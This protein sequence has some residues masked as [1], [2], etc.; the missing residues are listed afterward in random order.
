MKKSLLVALILLGVA[1]LIWVNCAT[2]VPTL[3]VSDI[4][5]PNTEETTY[6]LEDQQGNTLG[7]I[8]LTI[9]KEDNTYLFTQSLVISPVTD[10]LAIRVNAQN[11][12]PI[13]ETRII[14]SPQGRVEITTSYSDSKLT[15]EVVT[16]EGP[17]SAEIDIPDDAYDNDEV[18]FLFR[19]LPFKVGYSATYTNVVAANATKPKVTISVTAQ[20]VVDVPVGSFDCYKL[21]LSVA[22]ATQ[23]LWYGVEE[24]HYLVK[25]DNGTTIFLL[26]QH[27]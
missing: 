15:I 3:E 5:W 12:K 14:D 1:S 13:S 20:E 6:I 21:E 2:G 8:V 22:G 16:A 10:D 23:Y 26:T 17:Q 9:E 25:Y 7:S 18:L 19:A 24:P 27:P 11:L 4:P